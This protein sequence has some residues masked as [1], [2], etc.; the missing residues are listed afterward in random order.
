MNVEPADDVTVLV[1]DDEE[2]VTTTLSTYLELVTDYEILTSQSPLVA[3]EILR[4]RKVDLIISDFLMPEMDGLAFLSE[5]KKLHPEIPAILLTGYADKENAIKAI[6]DV[7][8]YQYIEKPWENEH[9]KLVIRNGIAHRNLQTILKRKIGELDSVLLERD[10]L[11]RENKMM[12]EELQLARNVQESLLPKTFP[13]QNGI[14]MFARY[15]PAL[16]IGGDF[17]DCIPLADQR[18]AVMIADVTG[19]GVQ[20]ALITAL[21]KSS[22]SSFRDSDMSPAEILIQMNQFL[23]RILPSNL[24]VAGLLICV[25]TATGRCQIINAGVP[26]PHIL[27]LDG[28]VERITANGLLLGIADEHVYRPGDQEEVVLNSGDKLILFTDG[29]SEAENDSDE[30]FESLIIETLRKNVDK[31]GIALLDSFVGAAQSFA[32]KNYQW[33]DITVVAIEHGKEMD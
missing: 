25:D 21:I 30:F 22:F 23:Y 7:G 1:V 5:A 2:M 31:C 27:R 10:V 33:D 32:V 18:F 4:S 6:N 11:A 15:I 16:E 13:S 26:H 19:H 24:F 12:Q 17:Y 8:L 9:L 14:S 3:L 28:E 20:A 29:V